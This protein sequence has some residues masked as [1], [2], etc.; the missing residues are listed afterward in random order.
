MFFA[1]TMFGSGWAVLGL[2]ADPL[3]LIYSVAWL[4]FQ[5]GFILPNIGLLLKFFMEE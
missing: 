2:F 5:F 4:I 1:T 3:W